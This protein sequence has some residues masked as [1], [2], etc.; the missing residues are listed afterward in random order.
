[1]PC[2]VGFLVPLALRSRD[3]RTVDHDSGR[4][5]RVCIEVR[6]ANMPRLVTQGNKDRPCTT[7]H[8]IKS[9]PFLIL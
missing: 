8:I 6:R 7:A 4:F 2:A 5:N 1:M 9:A 3:A